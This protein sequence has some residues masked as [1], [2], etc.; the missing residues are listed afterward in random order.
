MKKIITLF[1]VF[2]SGY[3]NAQ[4]YKKLIEVKSKDSVNSG[5][6]IIY[7]NFVQRLA[8]LSGGFPQEIRIANSETGEIYSFN[9]KPAFK[10]AKEN[11]FIYYIKPGKYIIL[12]YWWT[13]SKWYGGK[14]YTEPI[15]YGL[16]SRDSLATKVKAGIIKENDLRRFMFTVE[17]RSINYLGTWHFDKGIVSFTDDKKNLD[18]RISTK[19][20]F[21][22][23]SKAKIIIPQAKN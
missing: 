14:F 3:C 18:E 4:L 1:F 9:V 11:T 8:F 22:N 23:I 5:E 2:I 20:P 12:H 6:A 19:Y 15:F 7:G 13:Q 21:I 17:E 16:D 10:S